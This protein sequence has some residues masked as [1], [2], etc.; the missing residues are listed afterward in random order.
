MNWI[1]K[2]IEVCHH[3]DLGVLMNRHSTLV[4]YLETVLRAVCGR[5]GVE[6]GNIF[7]VRCGSD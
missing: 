3:S 6:G 1:I 4:S 7:P 2:A 5:I